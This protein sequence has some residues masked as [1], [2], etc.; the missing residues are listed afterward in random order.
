MGVNALPQIFTG[1]IYPPVSGLLFQ[2]VSM[3]SFVLFHRIPVCMSLTDSGFLA[4]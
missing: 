4:Y 1:N 3:A 2:N